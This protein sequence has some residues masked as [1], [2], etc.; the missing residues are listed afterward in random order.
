VQ[1]VRVFKRREVR[2]GF[3]GGDR[4]VRCPVESVLGQFNFGSWV[5]VIGHACVHPH[6]STRALRPKS[7]TQRC[8]FKSVH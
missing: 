7:R 1:A 5:R 6:L 2:C 4:L 8:R 3:E